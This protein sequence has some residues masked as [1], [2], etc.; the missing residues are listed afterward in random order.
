MRSASLITGR[1][2]VPKPFFSSAFLICLF[3]KYIQILTE[4]ISNVFHFCFSLYIVLFNF[5]RP[6]NVIGG[7][8]TPQQ[9]LQS[10]IFFQYSY[11][12]V[13]VDHEKGWVLKNWCFELWCWRRLLDCKEIKPV[14]PK[15]HQS[16]TFIGRTDAETKAPILWPPDV[17]NSL[18][19]KDPAAGIYWT[20]KEKRTAEDEMGI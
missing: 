7:W 6:K 17:K 11:M 20:Q 8:R 9:Y 19:G 10:C 5:W 12:D 3:S 2:T 14:N 1:S 18:T 13:R 16:W 15:G 4:A